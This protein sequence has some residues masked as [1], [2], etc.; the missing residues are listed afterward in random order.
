LTAPTDPL[1]QTVQLADPIPVAVTRFVAIVMARVVA[2][3][4]SEPKP[5]GETGVGRTDQE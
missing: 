3:P 4:I 1:L 5:H 2:R